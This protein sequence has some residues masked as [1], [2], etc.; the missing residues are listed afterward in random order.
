VSFIDDYS[1][2]TWVVMMKNKSD[3]FSNFK[4]WKALV[5]NQLGKKIKKL[6]TDNGLKFCWK[7]FDSLC[8]DE[9]IARHHT[10]R[11][12]PQQ[13]GVAERMNQ[14]LLERARCM[15][16][17]AGL[18]RRFW[19]EAVKT[20][21]YLINRSPHTWINLKTPFKMWSGKPAD[22]SVLRVFGSTTSYHVSEGKL[23]PRAKKGV[24][25]GY[26]DG[27]KGY[28]IWSSAES[29]VIL[30][31]DV[32][33]DENSMLNASVERSTESETSVESD[34]VEKH[35]ELQVES[36]DMQQSVDPNQHYTDLDNEPESDPSQSTETS[37]GRHTNINQQ[38]LATSRPRR[39]NVGIPPRRY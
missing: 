9:G 5:E 30:S 32:V 33:F 37:V 8:A 1:R 11:N 17:Q 21:C 31:R 6:H 29:R 24:F 18:S 19:A 39:S 22:Y 20:A 4:Q 23:E 36:T 13:N 34:S 26:G 16:S 15:L 3:A 28:R 2:M 25:V 10:V 14:T 12:T 38:S 7:D 27:V 35:V